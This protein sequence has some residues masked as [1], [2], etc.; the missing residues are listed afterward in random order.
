M[1]IIK[2][3]FLAFILSILVFSGCVTGK[4]FGRDIPPQTEYRTEFE[5]QLQKEIDELD[6][7]AVAIE[8]GLQELANIEE[9]DPTQP[10]DPY[11]EKDQW[12]EWD[13]IVKDMEA[14][15][16]ILDDLLSR[17]PS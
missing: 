3:S 15:Q 2:I 5:K 11:Y 17:P 10:I 4:G 13:R 14:K 12:K 8:D 1:K 6:A 7:Q 9:D 16:E